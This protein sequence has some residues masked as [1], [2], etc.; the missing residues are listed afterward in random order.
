MKLKTAV[1]IGLLITVF[2]IGTIII[3]GSSPTPIF[4]VSYALFVLALGLVATIFAAKKEDKL[5]TVTLIASTIV[6]AVFL[7][8]VVGAM[9][10]YDAATHEVQYSSEEDILAS[11]QK[12]QYLESVVDVMENQIQ[13]YEATNKELETKIANLNQQTEEITIP[14]AKIIYIEEP[15]IKFRYDDEDDDDRYEDEEDDDD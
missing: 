8:S 15:D 6:L 5:Q 4:K 1:G 7:T 2:L 14:A 3:F 11:S 13:T 10:D 12:I 9:K